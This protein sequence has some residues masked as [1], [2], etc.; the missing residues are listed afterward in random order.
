M[1]RH[2]LTQ[3]AHGRKVSDDALAFSDLTRAF[4]IKY[5][6]CDATEQD[7]KNELAETCNSVHSSCSRACPVFDYADGKVPDTEGN[8]CDCFKNGAKMYDFLREG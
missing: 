1:T 3:I 6:R 2:V 5:V 4:I 8:G 7:I